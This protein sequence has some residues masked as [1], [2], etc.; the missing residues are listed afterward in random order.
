MKDTFK[1]GLCNITKC[2]SEVCPESIHI[3][4]NGIIPLKERV[5][6]DFFDPIRWVAGKLSGETKKPKA[7]L[8]V[9]PPDPRATDDE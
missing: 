9:L 1:I 8:P 6:D 3:T 4:D 7:R 2:C 5:A